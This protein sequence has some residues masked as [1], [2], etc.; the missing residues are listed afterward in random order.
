M[1]HSG[2]CV[3]IEEKNEHR[4]ESVMPRVR[5]E[6]TIK[7]EKIIKHFI[8]SYRGTIMRI[9]L[10]ELFLH[11][12]YSNYCLLYVCLKIFFIQIYQTTRINT[13]VCMT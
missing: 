13:H 9:F 2:Y 7:S 12:V 8:W 10:C 5:N 4:K 11:S 3:F 6:N 1:T